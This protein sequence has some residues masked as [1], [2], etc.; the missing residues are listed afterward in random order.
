MARGEG[1]SEGGRG[2]KSRLDGAQTARN[3]YGQKAL[4]RR[5][6]KAIRTYLDSPHE[7]A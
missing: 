6:G 2:R 4:H 1:G 3:E 5:R 7:L